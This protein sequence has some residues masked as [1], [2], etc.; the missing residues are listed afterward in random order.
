MK[1]KRDTH[2]RNLDGSTGRCQGS[3]KG[4][5]LHSVPF[6]AV[7]VQSD[8][9]TPRM[10]TN[11]KTTVWY[12]FKRCEETGR[13]DNFAKAGGLMPGGF[14]GIPFNDSDVFKVIEGAAYSLA[15]RP[16]PK[17]DQYLDDLIAKIA[18]AQEP[19]GY[20]YTARR[21]F[22]EEKMPDMSGKKR[23]SNLVSSHELYN[24]G[25]LYEAAVAHFQA[26]GKK[27]LLN[28]AT[29]N[30]DLLCA[31]FGPGKVQEPPGHQEIE[32]G[33]CKL[34]RTTGQENYLDLAKYY[35]ELRGRADT[36]Q[37]RGANQQDHKPIHEQTKPSATPSVPAITIAASRTSR[38]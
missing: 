18:A 26:T 16:N 37:L 34:Y 28:V 7:H 25:H 21:L 1:T 3:G 9:W 38:R 31:T 27:T 32:I 8:F 20:L 15:I 17:L 24:V 11:R 19:D 22:P 12:D 13:I 29:K 10:E 36:H 2:P 4:L 23:W 33:L 14:I 5:P 6:T 35:V 30:A